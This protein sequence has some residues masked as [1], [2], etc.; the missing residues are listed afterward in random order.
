MAV[1]GLYASSDTNHVNGDIVWWNQVLDYYKTNFGGTSSPCPT[2]A[3][4]AG[5]ILSRNPNLP[6]ADVLFIMRST[7]D[8]I[9]GVTGS[10]TELVDN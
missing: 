6:L 4:I 7:C 1:G 9:G 5:L 10:V 3:G 2:A 8:Q